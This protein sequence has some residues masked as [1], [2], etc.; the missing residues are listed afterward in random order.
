MSEYPIINLALGIIGTITGVIA[1]FIS[2][3]T[4]SQE[5]PILK[6]KVKSLTHEQGINPSVI[7]FHFEFL[8]SNKGNRPTTLNEIQLTFLHKGKKYSVNKEIRNVMR[9]EDNEPAR[10]QAEACQ[11][12]TDYIWFDFYSDEIKEII[13]KIP[14]E[15]KI[16]HTHKAYHFSTISL[17]E[18]NKS[19]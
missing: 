2:Y 15:F 8:L 14:C 10:V 16:F 13:E 7:K 5:K 9:L 11:T 6:V 12:I 17:L 18:K 19:N 1:L 3:W 4:H